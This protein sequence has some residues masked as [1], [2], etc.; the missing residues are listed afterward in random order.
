MTSETQPRWVVL[1]AASAG[2]IGALERVL[3]D[4]PPALPAAIVIVQHRK[5]APSDGLLQVLGRSTRWPM[6]LAGDGDPLEPGV[7]YLARSDR[8]LTI[9]PDRC[10]E[11]VDGTKVRW[12][13]SSANPLFASAA[14]SFGDHAL[15]IVLTGSGRDGTDGVQAVKAKGGIVLVQDEATAQRFEMP[16]SAIETGA[17]DRVLPLDRIAPAIIDIVSPAAATA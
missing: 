1:L 2:G 5:A 10:F 13:L 7:I 11:Y 17:V 6:K 3:K 14:E 15:A 9:R 4:L 12:L 8:H 16:R